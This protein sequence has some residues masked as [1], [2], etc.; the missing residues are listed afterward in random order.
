M[1]HFVCG[2]RREDGR[3]RNSKVLWWLCKIH[4]EQLLKEAKEVILR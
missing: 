4:D 1:K 2:C 3:A